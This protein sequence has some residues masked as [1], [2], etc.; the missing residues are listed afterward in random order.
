MPGKILGLDIRTDALNAVLVK[1]HLRGCRIKECRHIPFKQSEGLDEA[2]K[3]FLNMS[4]FKCDHC[5]VSMPGEEFS[6]RNLQMPFKETEKIRQAI[7][8]ELEPLLPFDIEE[9]LVDFTVEKKS[10]Q[11]QVL[12]ASIKKTLVIK[13]MSILKSHGLSP[14]ILDI[15]AIPIISWILDKGSS[16]QSGIFL[17]IG[18]GKS[19]MVLFLRRHIV[20]IRMLPF[21]TANLDRALS[22]GFQSNTADSKIFNE[23][24]SSIR[25]F[26]RRVIYTLHTFRWQNNEQA[27]PEKV[28]FSGTATLLP[29]TRELLSESL[30]MPV[31]QIDLRYDKRFRMDEKI[32]Q[33]CNTGLMNTALS[34]VIRG[35]KEALGFN[36]KKYEFKTSKQSPFS[37]KGSRRSAIAVML[38]FLMLGLHITT[39]YFLMISQQSLLEKKIKN[40]YMDIFPNSPKILYPVHQMKSKI[41]QTKKL[42]QLPPG[43]K[44]KERV[45][46]LLADISKR[47]PATLD[48]LVTHTIIDTNSVLISGSTDNF[49]T[50]D[51]IKNALKQSPLYLSVNISSANLDRSGLRVYFE[52]K[53]Q[54]KNQGEGSEQ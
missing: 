25:C 48:I 23:F 52:M 24:K 34:L 37:K 12:A 32:L 2:L 7:N 40:L 14:H 21:D 39:D 28:F 3:Q 46:D 15:Q 1:S 4:D 5:I 22:I 18:P 43:I 54:R 11:S 35:E 13:Y 53:L 17:D 33:K 41:V 27:F 49:N 16:P 8:F 10:G 47:I 19:T 44:A 42:L 20:L 9:M 31:E 26:C 29:F 36:F 30:S 6:Y 45:L 51:I 50:V 38:A